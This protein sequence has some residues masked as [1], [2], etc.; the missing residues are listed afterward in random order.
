VTG[1]GRVIVDPKSPT[2]VDLWTDYRKAAATTPKVS[3]EYSVLVGKEH[4]A[5]RL[6]TELVSQH[7]AGVLVV[8]GT[9]HQ[10]ELSR[11]IWGNKA[12]EVVRVAPCAVL[13]VKAPPPAK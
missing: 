12:E 4:E 1:D 10:S 5:T 6:L 7:P 8:L 9:Y 2:P 11:L 3:V 13:V